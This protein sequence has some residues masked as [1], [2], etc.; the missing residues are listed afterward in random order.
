[1]NLPQANERRRLPRQKV[2][3]LL[4][5]KINPDNGGVVLDL[6]ERGMRISVANPLMASSQINF[7][8]G[9]E[10]GLPIEGAGHVSWL[11]KS[12]KTAGVKFDN[13]PVNSQERVRRWLG[14]Q[15][16]PPEMGKVQQAPD[17]RELSTIPE[18]AGRGVKPHEQGVAGDLRADAPEVTASTDG[19]KTSDR[20]PPSTPAQEPP[21]SHTLFSPPPPRPVATSSEESSPVASVP[22]WS[23]DHQIQATSLLFL[24]K[25]PESEDISSVGTS[26]QPQPFPRG[27]GKAASVDRDE[28]N[29]ALR[30][31]VLSGSRSEEHEE[32]KKHGFGKILLGVAFCAV[33]VVL[34]FV[35]YGDPRI[36]ASLQPLIARLRSQPISQVVENPGLQRVLRGIARS[37][38]APRNQRGSEP[39]SNPTIFYAPGQNASRSPTGT[40][41]SSPQNWQASVTDQRLVFSGSPSVSSGGNGDFA[42]LP[43]PSSQAAVGHALSL[44]P[45]F[46]SSQLQG[47]GGVLRT[48]GALVEEGPLPS[49]SLNLDS[50]TSATKPI[51]VEAVVGKDGTVRDVR[52]ISSPASR[53]TAAVVEAVKQWRYQPLYENGEPVEFTTRI[54]FNFSAARRQP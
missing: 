8:L 21:S 54:T 4:Y 25:G 16:V 45:S 26:D 39:V 43:G 31:A 1:M 24:P 18:P 35:I 41:A 23:V 10:G 47:P 51:V 30:S 29:L 50:Q 11:S 44:S 27:V 46:S 53:L 6:S 9:L 37:K 20:E 42:P 15:E 49:V 12:G 36:F 52:L 14:V 48:D 13:F 5:L 19:A 3:A 33:L 34:G 22:D 7:S 2:D 40:A 32:G 17:I 38:A 28:E